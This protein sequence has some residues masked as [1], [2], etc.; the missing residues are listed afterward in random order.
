MSAGASTNRK[1]DIEVARKSASRDEVT[2]WWLRGRLRAKN[3]LPQSPPGSQKCRH[4]GIDLLAQDR[5]FDQRSHLLGWAW[6]E[7]NQR[8]EDAFAQDHSIVLQGA[9][10]ALTRPLQGQSTNPAPQA[11]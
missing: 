3:V 5:V 7:T 11:R 8:R 4:L 1:L 6:R 9:Q 2:L 10:S